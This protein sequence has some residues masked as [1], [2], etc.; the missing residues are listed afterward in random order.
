[1]NNIALRSHASIQE[2]G[3]D[4]QT[5]FTRKC[6][7]VQTFCVALAQRGLLQNVFNWK[8]ESFCI[9]VVS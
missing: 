7:E 2:S 5:V 8:A 4:K 6:F 9:I 1:M 3:L